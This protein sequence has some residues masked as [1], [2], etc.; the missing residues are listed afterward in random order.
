[1]SHV[2]RLKIPAIST[3]LALAGRQAGR[4]RSG[5][6]LGVERISAI[7]METDTLSADR[8]RCMAHVCGEAYSDV[9]RWT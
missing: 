6:G 4:Q 8:E 7:R 3:L 1:V 5:L 2:C 9:D